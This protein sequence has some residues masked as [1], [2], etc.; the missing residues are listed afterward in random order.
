MPCRVFSHTARIRPF[1]QHNMPM[2]VSQEL[3]FLAISALL[4]HEKRRPEGRL[5]DALSRFRYVSSLTFDRTTVRTRKVEEETTFALFLVRLFALD[6]AQDALAQ[7]DGLG[8]NLNHLVILDVL[9]R[10]FE[11]EGDRRASAGWP[12][13][14][15]RNAGCPGSSSW[16]RSPPC[17]LPWRTRR[18]SCP[19]STRRRA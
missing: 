1:R 9:Q 18:R 19:R 17:R 5:L 10:L 8:G 16:T 7:A 6:G 3:A 13:P 12:C 15:W 2:Q 11:R 4:R 14:Q